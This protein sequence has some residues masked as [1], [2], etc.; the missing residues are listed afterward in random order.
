[1]TP[2]IRTIDAHVGGQVVR[3]IVEGVPRPVGKSL[4][5]KRDWIRR[6]ADDVRR[7]AVLEPRGHVDMTAGILT[8]AVSPEAHAGLLFMDADGYRGLSGHGIIAATTIALECGLL[9]NR[10]VDDADEIGLVFDCTSGTVQVRARLERRGGSRRVGGVAFTTVPSFVHAAA[11]PVA[12]GTRELRVD[13]A[14]GGVFHAIVDT[15]AVGIPLERSRLPELRRLGADITRALNAVSRVEHPIDR[16]LVGI[17]GVIF[18]GPPHDP[19][20][21]LRSVSVTG[22]GL[23]NRSPSGTGTA[24][25]MAVLDAMGLL[26]GDQVFVHESLTGALFRGRTRRRALVADIPALVADIEGAAWVTGEHV[27]H[28]D[29]DDPLKEG[30]RL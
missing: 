5:R 6:Y 22:S 11:Q 12:L 19:E 18:T 20:A 7:V 30:F 28:V 27:L 23:V 13:V 16:S 10:D 9:S 24:A 2:R 8:D 26:P 1:V 25:V 29:D 4:E 15:E 3:L 21:H 14:F 17:D